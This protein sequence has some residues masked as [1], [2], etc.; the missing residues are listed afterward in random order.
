MVQSAYR[1]PYEPVLKFVL[2]T[3]KEHKG[4]LIA[5]I[6]PELVE[7]HWYEYILHNLHS[8]ILRAVLL[9]EGDRRTVLVTAP[10]HLRDK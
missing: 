3:A 6:V 7:P 5:V 4:R 10:W 8:A 2:K 1:Q 9:L